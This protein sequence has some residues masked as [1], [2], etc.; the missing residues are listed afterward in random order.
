MTTN[1]RAPEL[2]PMLRGTPTHATYKAR[3]LHQLVAELNTLT[4]LVDRLRTCTGIRPPDKYAEH[5]SEFEHLRLAEE[6]RHKA[7]LQL[8][9]LKGLR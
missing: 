6:G 7:A 9:A 2:H 4:E 3:V 8:I 5:Y 1:N